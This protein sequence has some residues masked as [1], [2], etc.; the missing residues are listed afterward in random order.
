MGERLALHFDLLGAVAATTIQIEEAQPSLVAGAGR[1]EQR[2]GWAELLPGMSREV[3]LRVAA[4][5][6]DREL[7][8][9]LLHEVTALYTCGPGGGGGVRTT[10]TPR[11]H[12]AACYVPREWIHPTCTLA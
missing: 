10:L 4:A 5:H 8:E 7:V 9:T 3:R 2:Q 1:F 12:S 11:L 6:R